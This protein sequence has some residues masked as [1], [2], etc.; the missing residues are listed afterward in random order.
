MAIIHRAYTFQAGVFHAQLQRKLA[1]GVTLFPEYL[2]DLAKIS[3]RNNSMPVQNILKDIRYDDDWLSISKTDSHTFLWYMLAL[4]NTVDFAPSLSKHFPMGHHILKE[5]LRQSGWLDKEITLILYG[6]PLQTLV[7]SAGSVFLAQELVGV[8][9]FGGWLNLDT[10]IPLLARLQETA[11]PFNFPH[12][13]ILEKV[14]DFAT[15]WDSE[16]KNLLLTVYE[17]ANAMLQTAIDRQSALF[18]ILD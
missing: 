3:T 4:A 16:P 10:I 7:E 13:E 14:A 6:Q 2:L 9:Q 15:T 8:D 18:L 11:N 1:Q 5:V 17:D 12:R